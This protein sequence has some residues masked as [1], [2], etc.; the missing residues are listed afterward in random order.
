MNKWL[1][2]PDSVS[3]PRDT[4]LEIMFEKNM[5]TFELSNVSD[6]PVEVISGIIFQNDQITEEVALKL[7]KALGASALFWIKREENYR[8]YLKGLDKKSGYYR[9]KNT[10][11]RRKKMTKNL[12]EK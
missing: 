4:L 3:P 7:E 2:S 11:Y 5:T 10:P 1:Y 6:I 9:L 12:A 8:N